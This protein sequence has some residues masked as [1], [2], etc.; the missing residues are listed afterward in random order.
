MTEPKFMHWFKSS[1]SS[2]DDHCVEVSR[3]ADGTVGI[4]HSKDR[5]GSIIEIDAAAWSEFTAAIKA[6]DFDQH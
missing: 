5:Q 4:R 1:R 6:G 3:A 2:G